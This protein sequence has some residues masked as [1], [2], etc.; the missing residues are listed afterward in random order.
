MYLGRYERSGEKFETA[1]VTKS[2]Q[3]LESVYNHPL[4]KVSLPCVIEKYLHAWFYS[5]FVSFY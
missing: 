3:S 4:I 1:F 5:F 2:S